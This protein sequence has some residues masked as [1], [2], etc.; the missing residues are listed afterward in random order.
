MELSQE[1][2]SFGHQW[3]LSR[4][5]Y[6]LCCEAGLDLK[7]EEMVRVLVT[8]KEWLQGTGHSGTEVEITCKLPFMRGD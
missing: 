7:Q 1:G 5:R 2:I 8:A 4:Q 6:P 3:S